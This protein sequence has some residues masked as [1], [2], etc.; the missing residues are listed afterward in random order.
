M[1]NT[2]KQQNIKK[3]NM[4]YKTKLQVLIE[5]L[6]MAIPLSILATILYIPFNTIGLQE[7]FKLI[8]M[9]MAIACVIFNF[10]QQPILPIE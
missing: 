6:L 7:S 2:N 3:N 8:Y 9:M 1:F 10:I 5:G 4:T